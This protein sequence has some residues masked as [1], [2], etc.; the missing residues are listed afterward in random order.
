M[1]TRQR[2]WILFGIAWL[3]AALLS[4]AVYSRAT[5][6]SSRDLV[7][8]VAAA[9]EVP[10]GRR[11]AITD[12]KQVEV[13]RKD[14][15]PGH[16]LKVAD[17]VDRAALFTLA[18]SELVLEGKL[19]PKAGGEGISAIIE[20]GKR[21]F[22]VQVNEMIGV[23]GFAQPGAKVDVLFTRNLANGDGASTTILQNVTVL[24]YG[25]NLQRPVQTAQA[26]Q[27][28]P[29]PVSASAQQ[30][31]VTLLVTQE[32]AQKLALAMQRGKIQLALRNPL[33]KDSPETSAVYAEDL[34]IA[35]EIKE[36][37]PAPAPVI[38]RELL[39]PRDPK[40]GKIV[41]KVFRG[42]KVSEEI[43]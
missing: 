3:S 39:K 13:A 15:P 38:P 30:T 14:L 36:T 42:N 27:A 35:E 16:F 22:T 7:L 34:G 33:D 20:P 19:A 9:R 21:A 25:R 29:A 1:M 28:A 12:L 8:V 26:G 41:V 2:V 32:E 37:K 23:A 17:A 43:F 10:M 6:P 40:A 4:L 24:A 31:T 18:A 5:A 11:L